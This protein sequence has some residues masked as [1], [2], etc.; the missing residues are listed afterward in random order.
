M[1]LF[2]LSNTAGENYVEKQQ[3][4]FGKFGAPTL[5]QPAPSRARTLEAGQ[6]L[7][8]LAQHRAASRPGLCAIAPG[9]RAGAPPVWML[10]L[11]F[12]V[13]AC[14]HQP[15]ASLFS[16]AFRALGSKITADGDYSHAIKR[17]FLLGSKA[18]TNLDS[19]LRSRDITLPTKFHIAKAMAFPVVKYGCESWTIKKAECQRAD[20]FELWC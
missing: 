12:P 15:A 14:K 9:R 2:K 13:Q 7:G 3:N 20:A 11:S 19:I 8:R 6:G 1:Q 4:E 18:M 17:R 16:P 5:P 10:T